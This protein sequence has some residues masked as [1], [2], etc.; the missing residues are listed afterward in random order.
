MSFT[1]S[2]A[3]AAAA[4]PIDDAVERA[5]SRRRQRRHQRGPG[6]PES[7]LAVPQPVPAEGVPDPH[8]DHAGPRGVPDGAGE[9]HPGRQFCGFGAHHVASSPPLVPLLGR[10]LGE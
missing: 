8:Q 1:A 7:R 4:S 2:T 6:F 10:I 9:P 5:A 3:A